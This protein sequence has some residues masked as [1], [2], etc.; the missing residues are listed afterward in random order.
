MN[1]KREI[2]VTIGIPVYN[3]SNS[4]VAAV[5]SCIKQSYSN[6]EIL[7]VD[8][9]STDDSIDKLR[10]EVKD[11]RMR[12]CLRG[13]NGGVSQAMRTIVNEAKG[14]YICFLDAD[15]TMM[16]DRVEKQLES[17]FSVKKRHPDRM[18]ASFCGSLVNDLYNK[19]RYEL[20]PEDL[21]NRRASHR[22]G[23]GTGHS[24][25]KTADLRKLGNFDPAFNRSSD[26]AMCITFLMNGGIY[27]M[28]RECLITYNL[29]FDEKKQ[30]IGK[31]ERFLFRKLAVEIRSLE[32][33]NFYLNR[34]LES[35]E[36][37]K[38]FVCKL[39]NKI[40]IISLIKDREVV[41]IN[42]FGLPLIKI[43]MRDE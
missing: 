2:L 30:R 11:G 5:N 28:M 42:L 25:Y 13:E 3:M 26:A 20:Y 24:M 37:K 39:F 29:C 32:L 15:D 31:K 8:D 12:I 4:I 14:E 33:N 41:R 16:S 1:E 23:G 6:V 36:P 18:V 27:A 35:F 17:I 40:P 34:F 10:N 7:V 43:E 9:G 19:T 21:W 22:F 38:R